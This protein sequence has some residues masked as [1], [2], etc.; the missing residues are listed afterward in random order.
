[1]AA[2]GITQ[3]IQR[4]LLRLWLTLIEQTEPCPRT[5]IYEIGMT[6]AA[7]LEGDSGTA[8]G[9]TWPFHRC[10]ANLLVT[11]LDRLTVDVE[12]DAQRLRVERGRCQAEAKLRLVRAR[13]EIHLANR[14]R[15]LESV[16][17]R[18][19]C[20]QRSGLAGLPV[21]GPGPGVDQVGEMRFIKGVEQAAIA[22]HVTKIRDRHILL[23]VG[24]ERI[25]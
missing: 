19:R 15:R 23:T 20:R 12:F 21:P 5:L 2:D 22:E 25:P 1:M 9:R 11:V 13:G 16:E 6:A 14:L 17:Q 18:F 3:P 24:R 7:R 8:V 4:A 10:G